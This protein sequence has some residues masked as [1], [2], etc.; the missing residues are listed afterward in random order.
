[1]VIIRTPPAN[2]RTVIRA[3]A[4]QDPAPFEW[5]P[6]GSIGA[7]SRSPQRAPAIPPASASLL[8]PQAPASSDRQGSAPEAT[9]SAPKDKGSEYNSPPERRIAPRHVDNRPLPTLAR[10]LP[11]DL[12]SDQPKESSFLGYTDTL[13][14]PTQ[15]L[16]RN[17]QPQERLPSLGSIAAATK[18]RHPPQARHERSSPEKTLHASGLSSS[19]RPRPESRSPSNFSA[20][21]GSTAVSQSSAP[22]RSTQTLLAKREVTPAS[23]EDNGDSSI[24]VHTGMY[25]I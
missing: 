21:L 4:P 2:K 23:A 16:E 15:R 3:P 8:S 22:S 14:S 20:L 9:A 12:D 24:V 1:M 18:A 5:T 19:S 11:V 13:P 17:A 6:L 25:R 7:S 10:T